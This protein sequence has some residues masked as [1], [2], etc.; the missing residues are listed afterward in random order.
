[1][2]NYV[3]T[4]FLENINFGGTTWD[5]STG[6]SLYVTKTG[7]LYAT[8]G[9]GTAISTES[10]VTVTIAG[11]VFGDYG[12]ITGQS[13]GFGGST[14]SVLEGGIVS[15]NLYGVRMYDDYNTV[16][17]DGTISGNIGISIGGNQSSITNTGTILSDNI[18]V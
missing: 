2:A 7:E 13:G 5:L 6:N 11:Q 15:G 8:G 10:Q 12:I 4:G 14:V 1:M 17:N 18:A 3:H 16:L 9:F